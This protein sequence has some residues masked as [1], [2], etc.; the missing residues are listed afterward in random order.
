MKYLITTIAT[1]VLVGCGPSVPDIS[2][3]QAAADRNL[4]IVKNHLINGVDINTKD[5]EG[6]TPLHKAVAKGNDEIVNY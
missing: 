4:E 1:V 6:M 2:I 5:E 3:H